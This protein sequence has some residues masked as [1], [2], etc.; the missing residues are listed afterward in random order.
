MYASVGNVTHG[1]HVNGGYLSAAGIQEI[2]FEPVLHRNVITPYSTF[3]VFLADPVTA[4]VWYH[5][6]L[7][8]SKMQNPYGSTESVTVDGKRICPLV[9]WDSKI[10]SLIAMLGGVGHLSARQLKK[11]GKYELFYNRVNEEWSRVFTNI[12]GEELEFALPTVA[13]PNILQNFTM[14]N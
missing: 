6:M 13:V 4:L 1:T 3:P 2:A 10:T 9:T 8:G 11:D 14:C 7:I 5:N 12:R